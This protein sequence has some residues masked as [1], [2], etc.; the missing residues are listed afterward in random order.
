MLEHYKQFFLFVA[1][2][3]PAAPLLTTRPGVTPP[4]IDRPFT[5]AEVPALLAYLRKI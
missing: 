4:V 1:V 3:Q 2:T 5:D